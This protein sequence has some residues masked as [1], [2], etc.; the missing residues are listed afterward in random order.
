MPTFS[1]AVNN[2]TFLVRIFYLKIMSSEFF[3]SFSVGKEDEYDECKN[4]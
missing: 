3:F 1:I 4:K 2:E